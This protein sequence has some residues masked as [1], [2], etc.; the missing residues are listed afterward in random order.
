LSII[1]D[2]VGAVRKAW[3]DFFGQPEMVPGLTLSRAEVA[4]ALDHL[5]IGG[6]EYLDWRHSVVDL[7]KLLQLDSSLRARGALADELG[8]PAG[9]DGS[10]VWNTELHDAVVKAV[11]EHR[12]EL[13]HD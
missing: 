5:A 1:D 13:P 11:A 7:L 4:A 2:I 12:I 10:P 3:A 6:A 9:D 8:L